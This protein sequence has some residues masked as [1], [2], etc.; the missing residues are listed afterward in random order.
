[1]L[2]LFYHSMEAIAKHDFQAT[3]DDELSFARGAKLKVGGRIL[4]FVLSSYHS[5]HFIIC[6]MSVCHSTICKNFV[7]CLSLLL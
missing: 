3:A 5:K 6:T 1:M 4:K 2:F 7:K